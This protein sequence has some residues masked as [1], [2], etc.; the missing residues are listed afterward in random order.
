LLDVKDLHV[1]ESALTGESL[2]VE[3]SA[4]DLPEEKH[5][6]ADAGNSVFL[7]TAVQTGMGTAVIV[8]MGRGTALGKIA[9][10]LAARPPESEFGRGIRHFGLMITRVIMLLVLFVLPVNLYFHRPLLMGVS[11]VVTIAV[12]LPYTPLGSIL[13]FIPLP[14]LLLG[15]IAVLAGTC[16]LVVQ[17]VKSWF[18]RRHAL[19]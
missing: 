7:G 10:H 4:H 16:L 8:R 9:Q 12:I 14:V 1:R 18:Y 17:A 13:G 5:A 19:L 15:A 2:P 6:I 11:A 3:K